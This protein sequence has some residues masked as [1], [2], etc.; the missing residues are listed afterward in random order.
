[1]EVGTAARQEET[2]QCKTEICYNPDKY[3]GIINMLRVF[4]ATRRY[5][6]V[7][8]LGFAQSPEA[9]AMALYEG[10]RTLKAMLD[11]VEIITLRK[12]PSS[13]EKSSTKSSHQSQK[14][15]EGEEKTYSCIEVLT[16]KDTGYC[17]GIRGIAK[18]NDKEEEVCCVLS[19][20]IPSEEEIKRFFAALH[21]DRE[22]G[23]QLARQLASL[24]FAY[25]E[26]KKD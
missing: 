12:I 13:K 15:D 6:I 9:A 3:Q 1:V 11:K 7:D 20:G 22:K 8:R 23:L 14:K 21:C 4:V 10:L 19:V 24:A 18:I 5:G 26:R 17:I 2:F 16:L 25:P